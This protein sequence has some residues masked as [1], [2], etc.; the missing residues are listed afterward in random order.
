MPL[1]YTWANGEQFTAGDANDVAIAVNASYTKPGTG[2]PSSDLASAVQ[3][4]LGKADSAVQ[5]VASTNITDATTTGKAVLVATDSATARTA[6]GVAY[7]STGGTV[8][9]G[10]DARF[11]PASTA[12]S[13]STATGRALLT[14]TDASTARTT[15]GVAYGNSSGTVAQ[16]NDSRITGAQQTSEKNSANGYCGLDAGGKVSVAQLPNSI[17]EY[18]G[19]WN[20]STNTPTLADGTGSTG[21]VYR[22]STG[23]SRNLGSGSITFVVGDYCIYNGT[24]WEKADTTD[25]VSSVAG[26]TGDI[27]L[28]VA[29]IS[30][31]GT[32]SSTTFLRGDGA[33]STVTGFQRS[34]ST[35]TTNSTLGSAAGTDYVCFANI[36]STAATDTNTVALLHMDGTN[37]STT[38]TDSASS[39]GTWTAN[40]AVKISTAQ[41]KFGGASLV[42]GAGNTYADRLTSSSSS[43]YTIGTGNFTIEF[44]VFFNTTSGGNQGLV[45]WRPNT[46]GAYPTVALASGVMLYAANSANQIIGSTTPTTSTWHHVAVC[47]SGT[48]T[49]VFLNGTQEGSTYSD[50]N[51]YVGTVIIVGTSGI[52]SENASLNGYIDELRISKQAR[53]TSNFTPPAAAFTNPTPAANGSV[54]LPTAASNT[55]LYTVSNI[56]ATDTLQLATSS[57]QTINGSAPST[58]AAGSKLTVVSD[59]TNWRSPW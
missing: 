9:Q 30:A 48:S 42:G 5:S 59:G 37:N 36:P 21:D 25:A 38:F 17:M 2:I 40:G 39:A 20:A 52:A 3:T 31:T 51:N 28:T 22:V 57:S 4:S 53:Y 45:D 54:T 24:I 7:G 18:Q 35:P 16:G 27:T 6:L 15:L 12:I 11:T 44:F 26:R 32:P 43:N 23:G 56:H 49:K 10:N 55:N 8:A 13:D 33:W 47:R 29:D 34:V 19:T 14:T 46:Q 41:S 50:A 1:K 58:L